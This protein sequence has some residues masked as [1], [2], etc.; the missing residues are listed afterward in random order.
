MEGGP[1][2]VAED[3]GQQDAWPWLQAAA[4][5]G[6]PAAAQRQ[7]AAVLQRDVLR[8]SEGSVP[9]GY[10]LSECS[11][12]CR[13]SFVQHRVAALRLLAAV[14]A[15]ARPGAWPRRA[16]AANQHLNEPPVAGWG[17]T[18]PLPLQP[19]AGVT[20]GDVWAYA[21]ESGHVAMTLRLALDDDQLQVSS[22]ALEALVALVGQGPAEALAADLSGTAPGPLSPLLAQGYLQRSSGLDAWSSHLD[23]V[24]EHALGRKVVAGGRT[25]AAEAGE[26]DQELSDLDLMGESAGL[27]AHHHARLFSPCSALPLP[28]PPLPPAEDP[29]SGLLKTGVLRRLGYL[30][31]LLLPSGRQGS[32]ELALRLLCGLAA[33]G[34]PACLLIAREENLVSQLKALLQTEDPGRSQVPGMALRLVRLLVC[35]SGPAARMASKAGLLACAVQAVL[36]AAAATKEPEGAGAAARA[37][38]EGL[39]AWRA[40]ALRGVLF[41]CLD[42]VYPSLAHLFELLPAAEDG[43]AALL[44]GGTGPLV[45]C[46]AELFLTAEALVWDA[47]RHEPQEEAGRDISPDHTPM[48]TPGFAAHLLTTVADRLMW[49]SG[50]AFALAAGAG[51]G[52][53]RPLA[54]LAAAVRFAAMVWSVA[55]A[56]TDIALLKAASKALLGSLLG[57]GWEPK[58]ACHLP[59]SQPL[60]L[61]LS[62]WAEAATSVVPSRGPE[63]ARRLCGLASMLSGCLGALCAL[64]RVDSGCARA[65]VLTG[66]HVAESLLPGQLLPAMEAAGSGN[67][68]PLLQRVLATS[69]RGLLLALGPSEVAAL[70]V[71]QSGVIAPCTLAACALT[72]PVSGAAAPPADLAR[73]RLSSLFRLAAASAPGT[74]QAFLFLLRGCLEGQDLSTLRDSTVDELAAFFE[75]SGP[76]RDLQG[77]GRAARAL[78]PHDWPAVEAGMPHAGSVGRAAVEAFASSWLS[79]VTERG[80]S[81]TGPL[82]CIHLGLEVLQGP[83]GGAAWP[84]GSRLPPPKARAALPTS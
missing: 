15:R 69:S 38:S 25:L 61:L 50:C 47:A 10:T 78:C 1:L 16:G 48:V 54:L 60:A 42:D 62:H 8:R 84:A 67:A 2:S 82:D 29:A 44:G 80:S 35:H 45:G 30:L 66:R 37:L 18:G 12:L 81:G 20:W 59:D 13:S 34:E 55:G 14:L 22:A 57:E 28:S 43:W 9:E 49:R 39:R 73:L 17:E 68:G 64:G 36:T 77:I 63:G 4:P 5:G 19:L 70:Q 79:L 71:W 53:D 76:D 40:C 41:C 3:E 24:Y 58:S 75:R 65:L 27:G 32:V 31:G 83:R 11:V 52:P 6:D 21:V 33:A 46:C 23:W 74:E 51:W 56:P 72:E 7:L 26:A